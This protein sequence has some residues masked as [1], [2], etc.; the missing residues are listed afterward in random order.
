MAVTTL[1]VMEPGS[2]WPGHV[3]DS[4]HV[5]AVANDDEGLLGRTREKVS[6]MRQHGEHV[7]VAV[8]ACNRAADPSSVTRRAEV[9]RE[10][11]TA[12][13]DAGFG[14]LVLTV[15]DRASMRERCELLSLVGELSHD[16]RGP[17]VSVRFGDAHRREIGPGDGVG[18]EKLAYALRHNVRAQSA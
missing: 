5:V 2:E 11:L 3:G 15:S 9:A 4:E 14:R 13:G 6:S 18:G 17:T 10:L 8:L 12:V 16:L 7:R 1:I